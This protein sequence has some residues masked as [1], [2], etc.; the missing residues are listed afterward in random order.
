MTISTVKIR[1]PNLILSFI[2]NPMSN[3]IR[4][5][6]FAIM[7]GGFSVLLCELRYEHRAVLIGDGRPWLPLI[8]CML[9]LVVIPLS[10][11]IWRKGGK[12]LLMAS[13]GLAIVLGLVGMIF[14]SEGH[15][16]ERVNEL[17]LVWM[18]DLKTGAAVVGNHPPLLAPSAFVGLGF[19]GLLF[20]MSSPTT[21]TD[22]VEQQ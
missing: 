11:M 12:S 17:L 18:S 20:C 16:L 4:I 9:M 7:F 13:Y 10:A 19:I 15:F 6:H 5:A 2:L 3:L 22:R 14:H 1:T 21:T 8:F